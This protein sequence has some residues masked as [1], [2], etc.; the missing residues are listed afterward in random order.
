MRIRFESSGGFTGMSV[1]TTV[2]TNAIS[3]EEAKPLV[4]ALEQT[5]FFELPPVLEPTDGGDVR[6]YTVTVEVGSYRHSVCFSD[7]SAPEPMQPLVRQMTRMARRTHSSD[8]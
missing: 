5:D 3:P 4:N 1:S 6:T 7:K 8:E 2:D